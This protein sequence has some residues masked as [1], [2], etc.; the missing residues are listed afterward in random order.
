VQT[1]VRQLICRS[2]LVEAFDKVETEIDQ[3]TAILVTEDAARRESVERHLTFWAEL[4]DRLAAFWKSKSLLALPA[5]KTNDL[6]SVDGCMKRVLASLENDFV[7]PL[8][9]IKKLPEKDSKQKRRK[10]QAFD[11]LKK[12]EAWIPVVTAAKE[13]IAL[14]RPLHRHAVDE[15]CRT[16]RV[17]LPEPCRVFV[18]AT[19]ESDKLAREIV[20]RLRSELPGDEFVHWREAPEL[21]VG[22]SIFEGLEDAL[23]KYHL[24]IAVFGPSDSYDTRRDDGSI[25]LCNVVLEFGMFSGRHGRSR[26]IAVHGPD[27]IPGM[28]DVKGILGVAY[29]DNGSTGYKSLARQVLPKLVETIRHERE[30][31]QG[32]GEA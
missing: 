12:A 28:S 13:G 21:K 6:E 4:H 24:S 1:L 27:G 7:L 25:P 5:D 17:T 3:W 22:K 19:T 18:I 23:G 29:R 26:S 31:A 15:L 8:K 30:M 9:H 10:Q 16:R 32:I 14:L 11:R 20:R 2:L